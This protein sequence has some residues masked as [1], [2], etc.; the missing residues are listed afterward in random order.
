MFGVL[1]QAGLSSHRWL[2][3]VSFTLEKGQ[4]PG[5]AG[6]MGAGRTE[7]ARALIGADPKT[8]G[9]VRINGQVVRIGHPG[10]AVRLGIG[11]LSEDRKRYGLIL[12]QSVAA[13]TVLASIRSFTRGT[14]SCR[15]GR[16]ARP[17]RSGHKPW[18]APIDE[19]AFAS[20]PGNQR[21]RLRVWAGEDEGWPP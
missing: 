2:E 16:C 15:T 19:F 10:D 14:G 17:A 18:P 6:L 3:D 12:T 4:I 20:C 5:F 1:L 21:P 9:K 13:N 7:T 8:S 11:C